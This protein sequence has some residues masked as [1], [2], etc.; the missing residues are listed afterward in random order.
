MH[1]RPVVIG[2]IVMTAPQDVYENYRPQ[3]P[4]GLWEQIRPEFLQS[5]AATKTTSAY[6][7]HQDCGTLTR[8]VKWAVGKGRDPDLKSLLKPGV[9][10]QHFEERRGQGARRAA[11]DRSRLRKIGRAVNPRAGWTPDPTPEGRRTVAF[12]YT[13]GEV[14]GFLDAARTQTT[15]RW[16]QVATAMI[17]FG[18][19][20]GLVASEL[21]RVTGEDLSEVHADDGGSRCWTVAVGGTNPRTIPINAMFNQAVEDLL[22]ET[23]VGEP[24]VGRVNLEQRDPWGKTIQHLKWPETLPRPVLNRLR[25]T[26]LVALLNAPVTAAEFCCFAGMKTLKSAEDLLPLVRFRG[27]QMWDLAAHGPVG[28]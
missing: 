6:C 11:T 21:L 26:W 20:A 27:D 7:A 18:A 24:V 15:P 5:V 1:Q 10:E 9:V 12:P 25:N 4:D 3:L 14:R 28:V 16:C 22:N 23:P 19:G 8:F 17:V 2:G 13:G